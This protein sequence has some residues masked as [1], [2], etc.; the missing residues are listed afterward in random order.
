MKK[1]IEMEIPK[2][3]KL[4]STDY[5]KN[6]LKVAAEMKVITAKIKRD[7]GKFR[8]TLGSALNDKAA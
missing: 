8:I 4:G 7:S 2:F 6:A 1:G 3:P 5:A